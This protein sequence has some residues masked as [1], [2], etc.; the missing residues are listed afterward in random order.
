MQ[1]QYLFGPTGHGSDGIDVQCRSVTGQD[2]FGF[3]HA[4]QGAEDVLLERK[5][6]VHRFDHQVGF[7]EVGIGRNLAHPRQA[8]VGPGLVDTPLGHLLCP[9]LRKHRQ[10]GFGSTRVVIQP[11]HR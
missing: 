8:G 5:V 6:L 3:E 10:A 4:V 11:Q 9:G 2:G 1:P 7:G